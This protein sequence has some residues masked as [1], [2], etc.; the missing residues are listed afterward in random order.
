MELEQIFYRFNPWWT[1]PFSAPGIVR[2]NYV[3]KLLKEAEKK[4]I[5]FV[6]GLRRVGKTTILK[7][8]IARLIDKIKPQHI[9]FLSLDHSALAPFSLLQLVEKYREVHGIPFKEKI[10]L[11]FDEVQYH[12]K[13]EQDMK[14]LH[15]HENVKIYA[16]GSNSLLLKDKK[17]FLTG[18]N[19]QR[20]INPLTFDEVL[21]FKGIKISAGEKQL[22]QKHFLEYLEQG[23]MPEYILTNDPEKITSLVNNII[24]KD[25]VGKHNIKNVKKIQELFLLLCERVGKRL[26]YNKLA[27]ILGIDVE[28]VSSY[29]SYFEETF[30]IYQVPRYAKSL[31]EI[32]KSP[33]KIYIADN[34]LRTVFVGGRDLGALWENLVFLQFKEKKVSYFFENEKEIDFIIESPPKHCFAVEAKLKEEINDEERKLLEKA[35]C[36]EKMLVRTLNDLKKV[37]DILGG[38]DI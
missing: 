36:K 31:N 12:E 35:P 38:K 13:F 1:E 37:Q 34:G 22:Q 20:V 9:L 23:G 19:V 21:L 25:I 18:R 26:T 10:F 3:Q 27:N 14:I 16:S 28:T 4:H 5:T 8:V 32:V 29:L 24:Y 6:I 17:A 30:L 7:Q 2:E 33:K 11:F 15:D